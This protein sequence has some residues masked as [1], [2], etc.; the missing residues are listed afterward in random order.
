[1]YGLETM[2]LTKKTGGQ[3]G[4]S[5]AEDFHWGRPD[6]VEQ[7]RDKVR[8]REAEMVWVCAE[9]WRGKRESSQRCF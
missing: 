1:M 6:R 4:G 2:V 5:R 9:E 8:E 3:V 7:F